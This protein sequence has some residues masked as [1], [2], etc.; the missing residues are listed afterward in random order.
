MKITRNRRAGHLI[1]SSMAFPKKKDD[2]YIYLDELLRRLFLSL[3]F[4]KKRKKISVRDRL[5]G[6]LLK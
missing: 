1:S 3:V 6:N 2:E 4:W 5:F